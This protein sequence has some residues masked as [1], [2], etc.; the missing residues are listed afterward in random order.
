MKKIIESALEQ[1]GQKNSS[2]SN[3]IL[4]LRLRGRGS[5]YKEG[6]D[7]IQSQEELHL[8]ISAKDES[9]YNYACQKVENLL[10]NVYLEYQ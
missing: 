6:P 1:F 8:C 7:Q 3:E 9:I 5:G 4:K 10:Q 2:N